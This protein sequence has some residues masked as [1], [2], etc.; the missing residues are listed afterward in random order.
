MYSLHKSEAG[1]K[2]IDVLCR[3]PCLVLVNDPSGKGCT[4]TGWNKP[5]T[6]TPEQ[7]I[8]HLNQQPYHRIGIKPCELGLICIDYDGK[9]YT[10]KE[11]REVTDTFNLQQS[12]ELEA[13][14][15]WGV[16]L[17]SS[18]PH[19]RHLY[20]ASTPKNIGALAYCKGSPLGYK[21]DT[22]YQ[23]GY[24]V[25]H[26]RDD[27]FELLLKYLTGDL[28]QQ[29]V[30]DSQFLMH[31]YESRPKPKPAIKKSNPKSTLKPSSYPEGT[32][33]TA[34]LSD[35]AKAHVKG[36]DLQPFYEAAIADGLGEF[37]VNQLVET[38]KK[39]SKSTT[40]AVTKSPPLNVERCHCVDHTLEMHEQIHLMLKKLGIVV[41]SCLMR[42]LLVVSGQVDS[43]VFKQQPITKAIKGSLL[44]K[45][46]KHFFYDFGDDKPQP[47]HITKRDFDTY[48]PAIALLPGVEI[49]PYVDEFIKKLPDKHPEIFKKSKAE[50]DEFLETHLYEVF[51]IFITDENGESVLDEDK[52]NVVARWL[53]KAIPCSLI[54]R[55][56]FPG[57]SL[58][59]M[60]VL[61]SSLNHSGKSEYVRLLVGED[62]EGEF[63]RGSFN[64]TAPEREYGAFA[65][66]FV[67]AECS[68][69]TAYWNSH[70]S[71]L[72]ERL[73]N[74]WPLFRP[75]GENTPVK[76]P[77]RGIII[78][79]ANQ[80]T[81]FLPR[82]HTT[83]T[84]FVALE[85][86]CKGDPEDNILEDWMRANHSLLM[87]HAYARLLIEQ[88]NNELV[89]VDDTT[90]KQ[91]GLN[92]KKFLRVPP[93]VVQD[94]SLESTKEQSYCKH[95]K[96]AN[97]LKE[98][99]ISQ[100]NRIESLWKMEDPNKEQE[101]LNYI[102]DRRAGRVTA[103][104]IRAAYGLSEDLS[105]EELS[106]ILIAT[107]YLVPVKKAT[108]RE[109]K[110]LL[111]NTQLRLGLRQKHC[112]I[113]TDRFI[114]EAKLVHEGKGTFGMEGF[115][116]IHTKMR[117]VDI[118]KMHDKGVKKVKE[119]PSK[120]TSAFPDE[121]LPFL[122]NSTIYKRDP[123]VPWN[124]GT[125]PSKNLIPTK[126]NNGSN[127]Q[128]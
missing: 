51:D 67:G 50:L 55:Q 128:N 92:L 8:A 38:V 63:H 14:E 93:K 73:G 87:A 120:P 58:K 20:C 2:L 32:R 64:L 77:L 76:V 57:C 116:K 29:P 107:G 12:A 94:E 74:G 127:T 26:D 23:T 90:H 99:M 86:F 80:D 43:K 98:W 52:T 78:G 18:K 81:R 47:V 106:E 54:Y 121:S 33:H 49:D 22:R 103:V 115:F 71:K 40:K 34:H 28:S 3:T 114:K 102:F 119:L 91:W 83:L 68:E 41:N 100:P 105:P 19:G 46:N 56:L 44:A 7:V 13:Y 66:G 84:R 118:K 113:H 79:T 122:K 35:M 111:D 95:T 108:I 82:G 61:H 5:N 37:E 75:M 16:V 9:P 45:I 39:L 17:K 25:L 70:E 117:S 65:A 42:H 101:Y 104:E 11:D 10:K 126:K 123:F 60:P 30:L 97:L 112:Y 69:L 85:V 96:E 21:V 15:G 109:P 27:N 6:Y 72:K 125:L 36:L 1:L 59:W 124:H 31:V 24:A 62:Y 89:S 88:P 4:I 48:Y 53:G 110:Y